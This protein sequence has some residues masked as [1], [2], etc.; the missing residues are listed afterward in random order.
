MT[1]VCPSWSLLQLTH[2]NSQTDMEVLIEYDQQSGSSEVPPQYATSI[3]SECYVL[4][5]RNFKNVCRTPELFLSR[6]GM[7]VSV[8]LSVDSYIFIQP[9]FPLS[10]LDTIIM[11]LF[12][13]TVHQPMSSCTFRMF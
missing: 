13:L 6:T 7:M 8:S 12:V 5:D 1:I 3:W 10:V 4:A 2:K 9:C 11:M